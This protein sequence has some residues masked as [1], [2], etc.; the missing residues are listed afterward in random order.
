MA[1]GSEIIITAI[2]LLS[3][4]L[5]PGCE[6]GD[7]VSVSVYTIAGQYQYFGY[8]I[9]STLYA[10][11]IVNILLTDT[12]ITGSRNIQAADTANSQYGEVGTGDISGFMYSD[13][14]FYIYLM[15]QSIPDILIQGK[16]SAG[17]IEGTRI[18]DTGARPKPPV[19][20]FYT[21]QKK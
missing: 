12:T 8:N 20:G 5:V 14:S 6:K 9:D 15:G 11:G 19:I 7:T 4:I 3:F 21:L 2:G 10:F 13:S 1:K 16:F 18:L 17:L